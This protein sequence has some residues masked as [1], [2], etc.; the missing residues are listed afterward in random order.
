MLVL[1]RQKSEEIYIEVG[2]Q[3]MSVT[4]VDVRGDKVRLGFAGPES[5]KVYRRE[6]YED[7]VAENRAAS[8]LTPI[9]LA[10]RSADKPPFLNDPTA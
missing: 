9:D 2:G 10:K 5:F 3:R 8:S 7:I 4:I 1:T 6:V